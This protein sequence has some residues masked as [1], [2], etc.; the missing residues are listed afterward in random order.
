[1]ERV[2]KKTQVY[3]LLKERIGSGFYPP[4]SRLPREVE[5]AAE[6]EVAR[7]TLR[8]ALELLE[9]EKLITRVKGQGTFVRDEK[10]AQTRILAI[11]DR[12]DPRR[13]DRA[14]NPFLYI[15]PCIRLAAERMNVVLETCDPRSLQTASPEQCAARIRSRGV[16][17]IFWMGNNFT[18]REPLLE[19]VRKTGLPVLLPHAVFSD[20]EVTGFT[21]MGTDYRGLTRDGLKY[22][23]AQGHR[24]VAY[25]G[26]AGMHDMT[27]SD[28][29]ADVRTLRL[30][31]APEL[32]KL[33]EWRGGKEIVFDAVASLMDLPEPPTAII[34]YSD[35]LSLQIYE[36]LHGQGFRIP[37]DVCVLTIGGQIGCDFLDPP[38]SALEYMDSEIGETA[39]KTI[40]E[41]IRDRG[42]P[43]FIVTPH[44][45]R[46]RESTERILLRHSKPKTRKEK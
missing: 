19:T 4:G 30:D 22:F 26:G 43:Q 18:G 27:P 14:S 42:R 45:L 31:P 5:L 37:E 2:V 9:I 44:R 39:V 23:A 12:D 33:I 13:T 3:G 46:V 6:L 25:I 35:Y 34:S 10:D 11:I 1:M 24:R 32:L 17:G 20:A 28:Y 7:I 38:L 40:L 21:V 29:L 41:I 8:S 15:L 36:Y 16:Q